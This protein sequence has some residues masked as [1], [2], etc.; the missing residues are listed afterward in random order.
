MLTILIIEDSAL[1]A[2]ILSKFLSYNDFTAEFLRVESPDE[3]RAA[4][5]QKNWDVIISDYHIHA[6]FTCHDVLAIIRPY[7]LQRE[8][9]GGIPAPVIVVSSVIND[10]KVVQLMREGAADFVI[11]GYFDRLIPILQR[12]LA[13][14]HRARAFMETIQQIQAAQ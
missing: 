1:D 5:A 12:E 8:A 11:K 3:L 4:L 9:Q 14:I 10:A 7:N 13:H 2:D 6:H